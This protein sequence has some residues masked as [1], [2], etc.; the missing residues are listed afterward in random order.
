MLVRRSWLPRRGGPY[1]VHNHPRSKHWP[2]SW[3]PNALY[4]VASV[5]FEFDGKTQCFDIEEN[6]RALGE[7]PWALSAAHWA[8]WSRLRLRHILAMSSS[9]CRKSSSSCRSVV[10]CTSPITA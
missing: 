3:Y 1:A 5:H 7:E 6:M 4:D 2:G 8:A 9:S 10:T